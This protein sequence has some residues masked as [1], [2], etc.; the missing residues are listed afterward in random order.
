MTA[1]IKYIKHKTFDSES[2]AQAHIDK[3][4]SLYSKRTFSVKRNQKAGKFKIR[5]T[6]RSCESK[7][8]V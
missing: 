4:K 6:V 8:T 1:R 3:I 2:E 5:Y 7:K